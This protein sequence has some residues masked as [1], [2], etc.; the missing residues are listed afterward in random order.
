[1]NLNGTRK[2]LR[3]ITDCVEGDK[4]ETLKI[5]NKKKWKRT[6]RSVNGQRT[7]EFLVVVCR[8]HKFRVCRKQKSFFNENERRKNQWFVT[9]FD[10]LVLWL[11]SDLSKAEREKK[12]KQNMCLPK[13]RGGEL[14]G[15][16]NEFLDDGFIYRA[17][18][19]LFDA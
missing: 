11:F 19:S 13:C 5:E 7:N 17:F 4:V 14:V 8:W 18:E 2:I 16:L 10:L 3:N 15:I 9:L 1:M 12:D 6:F